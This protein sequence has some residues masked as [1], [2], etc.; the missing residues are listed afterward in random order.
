M[1]YSK[2]EDISNVLKQKLDDDRFYH[3]IGVSFTA[4][5]IAMR[6]EYDI[7]KA[8]IAGLLHD[9]AKKDS[10]KTYVDFCLKNS[11]D[12]SRA[13]Y[14]NPGL[15]H[16]KI[17]AYLAHTDFNVDDTDILSAITYHTTGRPNMSLLDKIIY[18]ADYIEPGRYKMPN[19]DKIRKETYIN[20]DNALIMILSDTIAYLK[21][22]GKVLDE[23][24][25]QT[26]N[27]YKGII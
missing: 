10:S 17:G 23:L 2:L 26:Y 5:S 15:L 8:Q 3:S 9:Y 24:T 13:E 14:E 18:I 25:E 12:V 16:A 22:T 4:A 6:Y 20:I 11:I 1:I 27:Y 19:L 21:T 7:D